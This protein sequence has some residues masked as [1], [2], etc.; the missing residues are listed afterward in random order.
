[1]VSLHSVEVLTIAGESHIGLEFEYIAGGDVAA[2]IRSSRWPT[3]EEAQQFAA[4]L[5]SGVKAMTS[6]EWVHR[7]LKPENVGLRDGWASPVILDFGLTRLVAGG[8]IT[9]YPALMG[10]PAFMAPEQV[11]GEQAGP[12]AD[13][14][15][16]GAVLFL[17]L[18]GQHPFYGGWDKALTLDEAHALLTAG[19]PAL[20]DE[21][22]PPLRELIPRL[23][24]PTPHQ[25]G[26]VYRALRD[27]SE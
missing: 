19:P 3:P 4:G 12:G 16:V 1:V 9:L 23:L 11:K 20:P 21:V 8:T 5:L 10:T 25:R 14:W 7:D 18:T 6:S 2:A 24:S 27:L 17:L 15:A 22:Q 13:L 26:S